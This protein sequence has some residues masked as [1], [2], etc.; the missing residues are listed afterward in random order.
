MMNHDYGEGV[1]AGDRVELHPACDLWMAGARF[2]VVTRI[3]DSVVH[4]RM[5]HPQ[6]R[7]LQKLTMDL[8]R[9]L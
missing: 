8:V 1:T 3:R 9:K 6:V 4:V 7:R 2:G 5:D